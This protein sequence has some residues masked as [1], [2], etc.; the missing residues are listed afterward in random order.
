MWSSTLDIVSSAA[1]GCA[2]G[3]QGGFLHV[4]AIGPAWPSFPATD[5]YDPTRLWLVSTSLALTAKQ[6]ATERGD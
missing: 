2:A 6:A 1:S 3:Q 4:E 5:Q